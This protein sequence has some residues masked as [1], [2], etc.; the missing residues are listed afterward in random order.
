MND[1]YYSPSSAAAAATQV[2]PW[3]RVLSAL[4]KKISRNS[5]DTWLKPTRFSHTKDKVI[6]VRVPN[7][8][9]RDIGDKYGDLIQE[10]IENTGIEFSDVEF[11]T[12]EEETPAPVPAPS[13]G[14]GP[15]AA[16]PGMT[17][18]AGSIPVRAPIVPALPGSQ[19]RFD[20]DSAAQLNPRYTFDN[21]VIGSGNQFAHAAAQAVAE[22]PS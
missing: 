17:S 21:F 5:Y 6:F 3:M 11:I 16:K 13:N 18:Y 10:A 20:F 22:R 4:E 7:A 19:A 1:T 9:F 12:A 8:D 2:N 14:F 15:H